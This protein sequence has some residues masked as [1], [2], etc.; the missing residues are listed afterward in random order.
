MDSYEIIT[1]CNPTVFV[2]KDALEIIVVDLAGFA[3]FSAFGAIGWINTAE[4][5]GICWKKT[6]IIFIFFCTKS[7]Y[8]IEWLAIFICTGVGITLYA[9][10]CEKNLEVPIG[11]NNN[12]RGEGGNIYWSC[13]DFVKLH[14]FFLLEN[15]VLCKV[16]IK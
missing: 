11:E 13:F 7:V 9:V 1:S 2:N 15:I 6:K 3:C 14:K 12:I 10:E 16:K 5:I 8:T 4:R